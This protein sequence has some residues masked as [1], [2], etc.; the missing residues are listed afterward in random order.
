MTDW[1]VVDGPLVGTWRPASALAFRALPLR[2]AVPFFTADGRIL[3]QDQV[4][5]LTYH[6]RRMKVAGWRFPLNVWAIGTTLADGTVLPGRIKGE[7]PE[8]SRACPVCY[9]RLL[10]PMETCAQVDCITAWA[11]IKAL[12]SYLRD[13]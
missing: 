10:H 9:G 13:R 8:S 5:P 11:S 12:Y 4:L 7:R 3:E 1:L 2:P 6:P